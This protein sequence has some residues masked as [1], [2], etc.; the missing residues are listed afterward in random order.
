METKEKI[1]LIRKNLGWSQDVFGG[2]INL[3]QSQYGRMENSKC[4]FPISKF[5]EICKN[6]GITQA[7]FHN[8]SIEELCQYLKDKQKPEAPTTEA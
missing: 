6:W 3:S 2:S 4:K 8:M 7:E 1:Y 5:E